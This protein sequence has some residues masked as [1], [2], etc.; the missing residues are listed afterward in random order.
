[1]LTHKEA[2]LIVNTRSRRG[3]AWFR[4]AVMCLQTSG[5]E[6]V[7]TVST[8]DARR[9]L[10]ETA[11][12]V[13][14]GVPLVIVGGGD[15]TLSAVVRHFIGSKSVLGVLPLGTGNQFARDLCIPTEVEAAC[16]V[17]ASGE[18]SC[19]DAGMIGDDY[20]LNVATVGLTTRIAEALTVE[21]KR[22]LGRFVYLVALVRAL[23]R[24]RPFDVNLT[25]DQ[26]TSSYRTLQ[27]VVGNGRFHAGPFPLAPEARITDGKLIVYVLNS[28]SRMGLLKFA[29]NLPGGRHVGLD[30]VPTYWTT[31]GRIETRPVERVTVDGEIEFRT[32]VD[33]GVA[34]R[35]LRVMAPPGF[36]S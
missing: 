22:R 2:A 19:V 18:V 5:I 33:F 35:A 25:T 24:V 21:D 31:R 3:R 32:P 10:S 30:E 34:P 16:E 13:E 36:E 1:M 14:G 28:V 7:N 11:L 26:G 27:V 17:I 15:G 23:R 4:D 12:A 8:R 9:V 29:L 6:L 20:F